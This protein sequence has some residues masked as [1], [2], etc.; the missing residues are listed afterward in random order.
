MSYNAVLSLTPTQLT[1]L[2]TEDSTPY[3]FLKEW[4]LTEMIESMRLHYG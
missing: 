4:E 2:L 1:A 3:G